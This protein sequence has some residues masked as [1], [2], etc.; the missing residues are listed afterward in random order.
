MP[1]SLEQPLSPWKRFRSLYL[2]AVAPRKDKPTKPAWKPK[3]KNALVEIALSPFIVP[4][5]PAVA[6]AVG[7]GL[8]FWSAPASMLTPIIGFLLIVDALLWLM[9]LLSY[10]NMQPINILGVAVGCCKGMWRIADNVY[11]NLCQKLF[12]RN[13]KKYPLWSMIK[14]TEA[15]HRRRNALQLDTDHSVFELHFCLQH[16]DN[17]TIDH[18][19]AWH[20]N[21]TYSLQHRHLEV[22]RAHVLSQFKNF[23][24]YAQKLNE[25][26]EENKVGKS[27]LATNELLRMHKLRHTLENATVISRPHVFSHTRRM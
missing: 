27:I 22:V 16:C 14:N 24:V 11:Q 19:L 2:G 20:Q 26:K 13:Y 17:H 21:H 23:A 1:A 5:A 10:G 4:F 6:C 9:M 18:V 25:F 7:V 3:A 12:N 15:L 8:G